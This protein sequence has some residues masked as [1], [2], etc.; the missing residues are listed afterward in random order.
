VLADAAAAGT[1][2]YGIHRQEAALMTCIVPSSLDR[3]HVHF[4]DG[5]SGGYAMA[6]AMLKAR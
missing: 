4:V 1:C 2:R 6:A 3:D 5:A